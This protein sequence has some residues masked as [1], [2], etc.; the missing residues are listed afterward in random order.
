MP[1][2]TT[3]DGALRYRTA[4]PAG[5]SAPPVVFVHGFLV[6]SRLWD[7]VATR[8]AEAG[9]RSYLIDWPLGAHRTAMAADA[10][11]SPPA[12]ARL[13]NEVLDALELR[14]V[15]LVGNDTGGAVC[16]LLLADDPS[17][18]G[19]V[20]LTNCDAFENFPPT[21]FVPLFH[22]AKHPRLTAA[23]LAPMR[24]RA[25]RHSPL[26][27]GLLMRRPRNAELTRH[28]LTPALTDR[29]VRSDI[30]RFARGLDRGALVAAAPRLGDF[31]GP[32]RLVWGTADRCFTLESGRRLADAF[33]DGQLIEVPNASTFVSVDAPAAVVD[34]IVA[35]SGLAPSTA[36]LEGAVDTPR[37]SSA[38]TPWSD[39]APH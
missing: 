27:F 20:V 30:A 4:G 24:V 15:T 36:G 18:I 2:I 35:I 10:D 14:D 9:V 19:R 29:R 5:A 33:A 7:D 38:S 8:L 12:V 3:T 21:I 22:A 25:V 23:L 39:T 28:W 34:A 26:G 37:S 17:R 32:A 6:D 1:T 16:Q 31:A 13:V 11:L